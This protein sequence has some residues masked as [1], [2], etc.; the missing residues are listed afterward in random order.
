MLETIYKWCFMSG[1]I[2]GIFIYLYNTSKG[3]YNE[4]KTPT[5]NAIGVLLSIL[6]AWGFYLWFW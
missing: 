6:Y 4:K 5:G 1:H 2:L 3:T